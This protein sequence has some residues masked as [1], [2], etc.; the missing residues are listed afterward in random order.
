M[1]TGYQIVE[2]DKLHFGTLQVV[3]WVAIFTRQKYTEIIIDNLNYCQENKG[4][5]LYMH[6]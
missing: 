2:Q 5:A 3:E 6:G 1:P 4:L